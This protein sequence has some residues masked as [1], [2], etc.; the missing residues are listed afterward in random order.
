MLIVLERLQKLVILSEGLISAC[1]GHVVCT[2]LQLLTPESSCFLPLVADICIDEFLE[3][4]VACYLIPIFETMRFSEIII[5]V[6]MR[7]GYPILIVHDKP[8]NFILVY[9][10]LIE[11]GLARCL[12]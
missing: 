3:F 10:L 4:F 12:V 6:F 8:A 5:H 9:R 1:L 7:D 11:G 2:V